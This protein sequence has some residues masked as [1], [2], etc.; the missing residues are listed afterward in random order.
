MIQIEDPSMDNIIDFHWAW[1]AGLF[2]GEGCIYMNHKRM[3]AQIRSTDKDV[4]DRFCD[5]VGVGKVYG[6][7][8]TKQSINGE[9]ITN[10]KWKDNYVWQCYSDPARQV[11]ER[12]YP[13]LG[14]RR[15][16]KAREVLDAKV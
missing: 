7:Y 9:V 10:P 3:C 4:L 2:E 11:I 1:A 14:H 5:I 13:L 6:P 8:T 12:L 15:Q 16:Q